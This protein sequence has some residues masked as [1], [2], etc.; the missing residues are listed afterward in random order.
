MTVKPKRTQRTKAQAV[1]KLLE[2]AIHSS[3]ELELALEDKGWVR[4]SGEE[5]GLQTVDR[6]ALIKRSRVH[7]RF[8]PLAKQ[9]IRIW[10]DYSVGKGLN[11]S[12][13]DSTQSIRV[14]EFWE[15]RRNRVLLSSQGQKKLARRLLVDGDVF[16]VIF[17]TSTGPLLRTIDPLQIANIITDPNDE[18]RVLAYERRFFLADGGE[19]RLFYK[20]WTAEATQAGEDEMVVDIKDSDGKS[21]TD[22]EEAI[23]YHVAYDSIKH[24]GNGLLVPGIAWSRE[25]K[26]FMEARVSIVRSLAQFAMKLKGKTAGAVNKL[27][28]QLQSSFQTGAT[29]ES[30]PPAAPGSTWF[31]SEGAE[32][33]HMPRDTGAGHA[34]DDANQIKLMFCSA[35]GIFLHYFGDPSTGN[36]ATATAME[37]PMLKQ[38][39]SFRE[40]WTDTYRDLFAIVLETDDLGKMDLDWPPIV[41]TDFKAVAEAVSKMVTALP[42]LKNLD[43]IV[44][45]VITSLG[46]RNA[47]EVLKE[48]K[49]LKKE[50]A[51]KQ[52]DQA[53][54]LELRQQTPPTLVDQAKVE[55]TLRAVKELRESIESAG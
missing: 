51:K 33:S 1:G 12:I 41:E 14:T 6:M 34:K 5:E 10:V 18:E 21:I 28:K 15:D 27:F 17:P 24:W 35:V 16:F 2:E 49:K 38:F 42:E 36:L 29:K 50:A 44:L 30:N 3:A 8:D 48:F 22:F 31:E 39:Q 25:V 26:N 20:D 11:F 37:L 55:S 40:L 19:K 23:V 32:L 13:K 54:E 4:F 9:A 45:K 53:A 46:I 47:S 7:W 52:E 43:E